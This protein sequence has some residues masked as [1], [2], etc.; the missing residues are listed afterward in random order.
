MEVLITRQ[1]IKSTAKQQIKG[2]IGILFLITIIVSLCSS[3]AN[4]IPGVGSI[5]SA[6][7]LAPAF[8]LALARIY[9]GITKGNT[10][11]VKDAFDGFND[12]WSAF[13]TSFLVSIFTFL[14]SL[15]FVI[16]GIIKGISY[17]QAMFI[18]A[19]NPGI[20]AREAI[21][22]SK[23]MMEGHKMDYFV[24]SLSF[25]GWMFLG[26]FTFGLLYIWLIPYMYTSFAHFYNNL[27]PVVVEDAPA[28]DV[29]E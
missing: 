29:G 19:E 7:V 1:Q 18:V 4:V 28:A 12:F 21:N 17:S 24:L 15:L 10:P 23:A 16:P 27:Q 13:K 3:L 11:V 20:G 2:K 22:R 14:W 25:I 8:S 26:C 6:V 9:L 5:V